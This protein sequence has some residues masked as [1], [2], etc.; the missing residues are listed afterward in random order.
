MATAVATTAP[1]TID[2]LAIKTENL[3]YRV[4]V[5]LDDQGKI[6]EKDIEMGTSGKDEA[7][8]KKMDAK[9]AAG[10]YQLAIEQTVKTYTAGTLEGARQLIEDEEEAVVIWN[11]GAKAKTGQKISALFKEVTDDGTNLKFE[12]VEG[13][14]DSIDLLKE[15]TTRRNLSPTDKAIKGMTAAFKLLG[16]PDD[17]IAIKLQELLGAIQG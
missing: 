15:A 4:Y 17:Q 3:T 1:S 10:E 13:A 16:I 5:K 11:R 6:V 8:W 9:V 7:F 2:D 14:Y 12:P